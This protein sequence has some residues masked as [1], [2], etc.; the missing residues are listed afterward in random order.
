MI[1]YMTAK[2]AY[3]ILNKKFPDLNVISILDYD[4]NNYAFSGYIGNKIGPESQN[5]LVNKRTGSI[6]YFLPM[7]DIEK[8]SD[9]IDNRSI[10]IENII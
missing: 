4:D 3:K 7:E 6:K 2:E 10:D 1:R 9:A 8:F 5:Y